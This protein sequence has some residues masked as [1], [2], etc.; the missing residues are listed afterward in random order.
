MSKNDAAIKDTLNACS[1]GA[2][3]AFADM[4]ISV[5]YSECDLGCEIECRSCGKYVIS[6]FKL[7]AVRRWNDSNP[8]EVNE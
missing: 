3:P 8:R 4:R 2:T 1:C 7:V 6:F 5:G